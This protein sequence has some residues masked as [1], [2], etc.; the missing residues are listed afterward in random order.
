[1]PHNYI[2]SAVPVRNALFPHKALVLDE[3]SVRALLL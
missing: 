1:M 3:H 2:V